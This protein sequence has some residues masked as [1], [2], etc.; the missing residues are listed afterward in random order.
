M[1]IF[2]LIMTIVKELMPFLKESLLEGQTFKAWLKTNWLTFAWLVNTLIMTLMIAHLADTLHLSRISEQKARQE[3]QVIKRPAE[4][5]VVL[6]KG[7]KVENTRLTQ[8]INTLRS[9]NQQRDLLIAQ[10]E[11]WMKGCGVNLETGQCRVVRTPIVKPTSR[12]KTRPK[13]APKQ[14]PET[15]TPPEPEQKTGFF[16]KLRNIFTREKKADQ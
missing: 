9:D 2:A 13:S 4:Q 14:P 8:E 7:L 3:V 1:S 5:L 10:Y 12:P 16:K 11:D 6:Y 15:A